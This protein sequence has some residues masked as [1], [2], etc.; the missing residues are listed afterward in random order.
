MGITLEV[1]NSMCATSSGCSYA[2]NTYSIPSC[3]LSSEKDRTLLLRPPTFL[4]CGRYFIHIGSRKEQIIVSSVCV[5]VAQSCP[6]LCHPMDSRPLCLCPWDS[7]VKNIGAG[8]QFLPQGIFPTQGLNSGLP[9]CRQILYHLNHQ[10]SPDYFLP[11]Q[12]TQKPREAK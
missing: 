6:T 1:T 11:H 10:G 3:L 5:L 9:H 8:S 2:V 7:S 4:A 12:K